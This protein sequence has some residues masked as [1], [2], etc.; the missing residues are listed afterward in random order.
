MPADIYILSKCHPQRWRQARP[1]SG[2]L[3]IFDHDPAGYRKAYTWI[4]KE[5]SKI[6]PLYRLLIPCGGQGI[7]DLDDLERARRIAPPGPQNTGYVECWPDGAQFQVERII[8]D[9]VPTNPDELEWPSPA[10][11]LDEPGTVLLSTIFRCGYCSERELRF[12]DIFTGLTAV[13]QFIVDRAR[14]RSATMHELVSCAAARFRLEYDTVAEQY[15]LLTFGNRPLILSPPGRA[16]YARVGEIDPSIPNW[17]VNG[18]FPLD[19][20]AVRECFRAMIRKGENAGGWEDLKPSCPPYIFQFGDGR[21]WCNSPQVIGGGIKPPYGWTLA[22]FREQ[23]KQKVVSSWTC[24]KATDTP[25]PIDF[26]LVFYDPEMTRLVT[27]HT[28]REYAVRWFELKI[29]SLIRAAFS[30]SFFEKR[31]EQEYEYLRQIWSCARFDIR[32]DDEVYSNRMYIDEDLPAKEKR[33]M[34]TF[35]P[36][37]FT[38]LH[39]LPIWKIGPHLYYDED[40]MPRDPPFA[41]D[42]WMKELEDA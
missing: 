33:L 35:G 14:E 23:F 17:L 30:R 7:R 31:I 9:E 12:P 1:D 10:R 38:Y 42:K 36:D 37:N 20:M 32:K 24:V 5:W 13:Q 21:W 8:I 34:E 29:Q 40:V 26:R 28:F 19:P 15:E 3:L 39:E 18:S 27:F 16:C 11:I 2:A 6:G 25:L 41:S 4:T 22:R